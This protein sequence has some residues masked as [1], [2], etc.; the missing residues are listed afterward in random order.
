MPT[1]SLLGAAL[2]AAG[3]YASWTWDLPTGPAIVTTFGATTALVTL[4]FWSRKLTKRRAGTFACVLAALAGLLLVA[5]PKMDQP[6]LD[7]LEDIAPPV[8]TVFLDSGER[9][10]RRETLESLERARTELARL[11]ALDQDVR[12][13]KV[14]ME[15][16]KAERLRQYVAGMSEISA[17]D[18]LVLR[19]L[20]GKARERQRF[21][22][23][24][25]LL[26][27]GAGGLY[28]LMRRPSSQ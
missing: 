12:W 9:L 22:L 11:R 15:P 19:H 13:G 25:P 5:F 18:Q 14:E 26:L 17:G 24:L 7:A 16:E 3:L 21:A 2:T 28:I 6:W 23:G 1:M 10:T 4:G 27:F 20:H 8:Q